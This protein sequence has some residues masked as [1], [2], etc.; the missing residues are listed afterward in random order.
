M[1]AIL[2]YLFDHKTLTKAEAKE[3]LTNIAKGKYSHSEI[4]AFISVYLM[5][6][7]TVDELSGFRDALLELCIPVNL[8]GFDTI[9]L[10]GTGG[11]GKNTFNISTLTAFVVAGAGAKV[12]KHGNYGVSSSCGSSN[13]MEYLGYKFQTEEAKLRQ[14]ME[15][16]GICFIHA[17]LF[18][19]AMKNVAPVRKE[20]KV[21]TFFNMLGP[22]VNPSF[23]KK[24]MVGVYSLELARLYKYLYQQTDKQFAIVHSLDGYDEISLTGPFKMIS[25]TTDAILAPENIGMSKLNSEDIGGGNSIPEAA[26]IFVKILEGKGTESQN[27]VVTANAAMALNCYYPEKSMEDCI[28]LATDSLKGQKALKVFNKLLN[29]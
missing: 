26:E 3:V 25:N 16:C 23:P 17:P 8:N 9:D 20:L 11:D 2:N 24:Q 13:V 14:E 4:A 22:M 7:I 28:G 10:C 15:T 21:K 18:N 6:S 1:K 19:P 12:A 27:Q 5:R 29:R